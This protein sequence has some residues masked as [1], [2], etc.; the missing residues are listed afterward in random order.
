M[1]A[2]GIEIAKKRAV[3]FALEQ[4]NQGN[5]INLT[6]TSKYFEIKEDQDNREIRNFQK[7]VFDFFNSINPDAIAIIARQTKGR[8]ASSSFSFKLEG[9]IQCYGEADVEFVS[10][11]TIS[12]YYKKNTLLVPIDHDYQENAVKLAYYLLNR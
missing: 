8:F 1:K 4:D 2:I 12:A 11:R 10:P 5:Y 7:S 3:C 6:G 9:L